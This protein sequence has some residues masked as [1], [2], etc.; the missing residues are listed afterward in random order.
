[1]KCVSPLLYAAS[2]VPAVV[3]VWQ[4]MTFVEYNIGFGYDRGFGLDDFTT[5]YFNGDVAGVFAI[6]LVGSIVF[7]ALTQALMW[8]E[9]LQR[10]SFLDHLRHCALLYTLLVLLGIALVWAYGGNYGA[11]ASGVTG[12]YAV[13]AL[14]FMI[15]GYAI[16]INAALIALRHRSRTRLDR[17]RYWSSI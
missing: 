5:L 12:G 13:V 9:R 15:V 14:S 6:I 16:V 8:V 2:F 7:G 10:P 1:M 11:N 3:A 4:I 17:T